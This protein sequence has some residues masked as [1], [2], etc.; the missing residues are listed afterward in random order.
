[1][2]LRDAREARARLVAARDKLDGKRLRATR[3]WRTAVQADAETP[4]WGTLCRREDFVRKVACGIESALL[5]CEGRRAERLA[6][7]EAILG[8]LE[9]LSVITRTRDSRSDGAHFAE[10]VL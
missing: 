10:G 1:V 6:E 4:H 3:G 7:R 9:R 2:L 8:A 5:D